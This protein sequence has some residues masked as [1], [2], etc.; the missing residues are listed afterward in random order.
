MPFSARSPASSCPQGL[1]KPRSSATLF[2]PR[3][4]KEGTGPGIKGIKRDQH[5]GP[6][7]YKIQRHLAEKQSYKFRFETG[8]N[9]T[10]WD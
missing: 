3:T 8:R 10:Y 9:K 6:A 7:Y 4:K 5:G 2:Y 1:T